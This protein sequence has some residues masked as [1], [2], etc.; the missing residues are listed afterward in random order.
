MVWGFGFRVAIFRFRVKGIE[1]W[2]KFFGANVLDPC[3]D[4]AC[5]AYRFRS[6]ASSYGYRKKGIQ[7]NLALR[8]Q[9][10]PLGP[11]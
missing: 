5:L 7:G 4:S 9:H 8:K 3:S 11:P 10:S 6:R 2:V 1:F